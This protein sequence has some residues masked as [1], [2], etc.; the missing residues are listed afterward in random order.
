MSKDFWLQP[1]VEE[2]DFFS[3]PQIMQG[4]P[5][6]VIVDGTVNSGIFLEKAY[7]NSAGRT[8]LHSSHCIF[9]HS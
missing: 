9:G 5:R 2:C 6:I 1:L 4:L 8:T 3:V 7:I